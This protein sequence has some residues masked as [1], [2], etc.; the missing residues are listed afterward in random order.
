MKYLRYLKIKNKSS[1]VIKLSVQS[2]SSA[3]E[4]HRS[5]RSGDICDEITFI[6]IR[7]NI[8]YVNRFTYQRSH[9]VREIRTL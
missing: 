7:P 2:S 8:E 5:N 6:Y 4:L 3:R 9:A 1:R